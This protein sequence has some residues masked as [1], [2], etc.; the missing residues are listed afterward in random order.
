MADL[1]QIEGQFSGK[2]HGLSTGRV[3]SDS[4]QIGPS[5]ADLD[6]DRRIRPFQHDGVDV[7]EIDRQDR[8][9]LGGQERA[10]RVVVPRRRRDR[11]ARRILRIVEAATR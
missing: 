1:L 8:F 3:I 2:L 5:T 10:P 11:R 9:G 4:Q 7:Q 6:D